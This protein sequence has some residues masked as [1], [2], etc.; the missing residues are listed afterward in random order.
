MTKVFLAIIFS[1]LKTFFKIPIVVF[2]DRATADKVRN[3]TLFFRRSYYSENTVFVE[4]SISA[5]Q[6]LSLFLDYLE[7]NTT[8]IIKWD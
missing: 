6:A 7:G 4:K 3:Q 2:V 5:E 8:P 1:D